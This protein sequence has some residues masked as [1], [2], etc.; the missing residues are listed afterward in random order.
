MDEGNLTL[1]VAMQSN[2][3]QNLFWEDLRSVQDDEMM[4]DTSF[5]QYLHLWSFNYIFRLL[6]ASV[7]YSN[8][9]KRQ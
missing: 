4:R 3:Q 6:K 5:K 7:G 1:S 2:T 9:C 8:L